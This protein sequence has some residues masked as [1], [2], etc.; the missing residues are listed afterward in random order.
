MITH[1]SPFQQF[2]LF[3]GK[4]LQM[5]QWATSITSKTISD[6]PYPYIAITTTEKKNAQRLI[7]NAM[8]IGQ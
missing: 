4:E 6:F 2:G 1:L 8:R 7:S 3:R 5:I